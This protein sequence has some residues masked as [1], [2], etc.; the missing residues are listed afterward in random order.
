MAI[1][2][3]LSMKDGL[4][5]MFSRASSGSTGEAGVSDLSFHLSINCRREIVSHMEESCLLTAYCNEELD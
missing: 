3:G 1:L 5:D 2:L 4:G